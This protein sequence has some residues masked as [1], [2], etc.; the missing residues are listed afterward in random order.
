VPIVEWVKSGSV[1]SR[2]P[3][4]GC[5]QVTGRS[6][7]NL[8][9]THR[10]R[11]KRLSDMGLRAEEQIPKLDVVGSNPIARYPSISPALTALLWFAGCLGAF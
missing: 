10:T 4:V 5:C 1:A 7:V 9:L 3:L 2:L 11:Y 6:P 8:I